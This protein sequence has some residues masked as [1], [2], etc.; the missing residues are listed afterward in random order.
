MKNIIIQLSILFFTFNFS[1][2]QTYIDLEDNYEV[3]SNSW[4]VINPGNYTVPDP[5]NDGLLQINDK[6]NIIID[7]SGVIADGTNYQ[8]YMIKKVILF[9][10]NG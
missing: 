6:E 5:G 7:G 9:Q 3:P 2:S 1:I 8:G 4:I 10:V